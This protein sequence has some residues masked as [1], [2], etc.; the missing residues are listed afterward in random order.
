MALTLY[1]ISQQVL[2]VPHTDLLPKQ[3]DQIG[4]E[5]DDQQRQEL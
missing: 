2:C 5:D 1:P 4:I 3:I